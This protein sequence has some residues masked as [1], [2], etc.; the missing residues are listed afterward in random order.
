MEFN[1]ETLAKE[2]KKTRMNIRRTTRNIVLVSFLI[3][4]L[5]V[6]PCIL[7]DIT[8]IS[9]PVVALFGML[10]FF[11]TI[12]FFLGMAIVWRKKFS[13]DEENNKP[14]TIKE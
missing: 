11:P 10:Y 2:I 6:I 4:T 5:T 13:L 7:M 8:Q 14:V 3:F 12:T 9:V 1:E